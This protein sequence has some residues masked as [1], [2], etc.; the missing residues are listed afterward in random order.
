MR[1][2]GEG[3]GVYGL[4]VRFS[5]FRFGVHVDVLPAEGVG[6][7]AVGVGLSLRI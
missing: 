5:G 3:F 2:S 7:W 6:L 1:V 4:G